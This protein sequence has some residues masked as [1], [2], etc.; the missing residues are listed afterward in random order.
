MWDPE[1]EGRGCSGPG[2]KLEVGGKGNCL[3]VAVIPWA[4]GSEGF[5][6]RAGPVPRVR[7][8]VAW[9]FDGAWV[10]GL[11]VAPGEGRLDGCKG[12][13]PEPT[14]RF[15]TRGKSGS[16]NLRVRSEATPRLRRIL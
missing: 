3:Y 13:G 1:K 6:G 11:G 5:G 4:S 12:V 9:G 14:S 10:G 15:K 7:P 2:G 8:E 16:L